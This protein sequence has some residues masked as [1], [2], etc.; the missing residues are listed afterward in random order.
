MISKIQAKPKGFTL[1][2]LLIVIAVL[3]IL[4][5]ALILVLN[6]AETLRKSRDAQRITDLSTLKTAIGLYV[7]NVNSPDL[8]GS[9]VNGC[10]GT[11][12]TA[13]QIFYSAELADTSSCA[14]TV[15]EGTDVTTGS[16]FSAIDFC[17]YP[18]TSG[19]SVIDGSGWVPVNFTAIPGG[20]PISNLPID[21]INTIASATAPVSTD[22]V[23]RYACQA[24]GGT[25]PSTVFE[26][27]AT[28]E[29]SAYTTAPDDKRARDGG[30]NLNYYEVGTDLRLIGAGANF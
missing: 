24:A 22:L 21:P 15:A 13:A 3:A 27:D 1:L 14:A 5:V 30:D 29:S 10:L 9:V 2:E 19:A 26:I 17:K 20:S 12:N 4:S 7:T 11:G 18:G 25:S 16:T 28:L 8:D 6:P 23:Y